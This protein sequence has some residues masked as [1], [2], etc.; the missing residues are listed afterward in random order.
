[1]LEAIIDKQTLQIFCPNCSESSFSVFRRDGLNGKL[2]R[3][4]CKCE[5][6]GQIFVCWEDKKGKLII[7]EGGRRG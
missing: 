2:I 5:A 1:M 7:M 4:H 6:C 3:N